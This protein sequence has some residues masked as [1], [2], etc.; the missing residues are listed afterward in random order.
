MESQRKRSQNRIQ[1]KISD[2]MT[3]MMRTAHNLRNPVVVKGMIEPFS[4]SFQKM[5][6]KEYQGILLDFPEYEC[7]HSLEV[8]FGRAI[9]SKSDHKKTNS[10]YEFYA[11]KGHVLEL[12]LTQFS[13]TGLIKVK[14]IPEQLVNLESLSHL[15]IQLTEITEMT[16]LFNKLHFL[17]Y[18]NLSHNRISRIMC[19]LDQLSA[20]QH[21]DLSY[22][23]LKDCPISIGM[24]NSLEDLD[25]SHNLLSS[26]PMLVN[27]FEKLKLKTL[28]LSHNQF[29]EIPPDM[30]HLEEL[31]ILDLHQNRIEFDQKIDHKLPSGVELILL[32]K[33]PICS[34]HSLLSECKQRFWVI[35]AISQPFPK[36]KSISVCPIHDK[37]LLPQKRFVNKIK[38]WIEYWLHC[39]V[40]K[41]QYSEKINPSDQVISDI[42][43][44]DNQQ[45]YI[46]E[47]EPCPPHEMQLYEIGDRV[48]LRC[49][50]C[51][52]TES[53][54]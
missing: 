34:K 52:K 47:M 10:C 44:Q 41:C 7:M 37:I 25:L 51:N 30:I 33:N 29:S 45:P 5:D 39:P 22:N 14:K 16:P 4:R 48:I 21:L 15:E 49:I 26:F 38:N 32:Y 31:K 24:L 35:F 28:D 46:I 54:I 42:S 19:S 50:K 2:F 1:K 23:M 6:Q 9:P 8:I 3:D 40:K 20:L 36:I 12:K 43:L 18:L 53:E 11:E 27:D 17:R 13:L